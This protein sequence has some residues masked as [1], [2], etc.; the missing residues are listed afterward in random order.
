M[1]RWMLLS[2][3]GAPTEWLEDGTHQDHSQVMTAALPTLKEMQLLVL[4][5]REGQRAPL[6]REVVSNSHFRVSDFSVIYFPPY[7]ST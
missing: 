5:D 4:E 3:R 2:E 1:H 6:T 7:W